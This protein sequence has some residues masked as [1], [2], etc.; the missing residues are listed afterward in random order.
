MDARRPLPQRSYRISA[1]SPLW[2]VDIVLISPQADVY[3]SPWRE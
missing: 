3:E 1:K 2:L